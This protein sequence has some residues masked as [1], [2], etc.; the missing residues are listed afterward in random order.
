MVRDAGRPRHQ[1][2][3]ALGL[4]EI[5]F[6]GPQRGGVFETPSKFHVTIGRISPGNLHRPPAR[7]R[8]LPWSEGLKLP[9]NRVRINQLLQRT[10]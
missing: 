9:Q 6:P 1:N 5:R 8:H 2:L 3:W 4:V 10:T 7:R